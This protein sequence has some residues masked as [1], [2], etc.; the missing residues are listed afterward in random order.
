VGPIG[1]TFEFLGGCGDFNPFSNI[2]LTL[3]D[4][5]SSECSKSALASGTFQPTVRLTGFCTNFP[6][7]A[8]ANSNC[9]A[10]DGTASFGSIFNG[11]NPNGTWSLYIFDNFAGDSPGSIGSGWTITI[12][13]A[14]AAAGTSTTV[15]SSLNPSF[16]SAPNNGVTLTAT[17]T[18]TSNSQPVTQSSVTFFDGS[19]NLGTISLNS[20]G[21]AALATSFTTEGN[22]HIS[23]DFNSTASFG[24]SSGSLVQEADNQT[25]DP[26][27]A[28][29]ERLP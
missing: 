16:T 12:T 5:A 22:H 19:S 8:P 20:A 23:A 21:Q 6:S 17:V 7:P 15:T 14:A 10:P 13:L 2:T 24:A 11:S 28:T 3:D 18:Q 26:R 4:S 9:A 29:P 25:T 1:A 27:S